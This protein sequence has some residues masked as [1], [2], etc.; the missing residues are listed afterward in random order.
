M[1]E[2]DRARESVRAI[3]RDRKREKRERDREEKE[4][5]GFGG[6]QPRMAPYLAQAFEK[7]SSTFFISSS[8]REVVER[9]IYPFLCLISLCLFLYPLSLFV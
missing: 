6:R 8:L 2:R 4:R 3:E 5:P 7:S 1:S 9:I